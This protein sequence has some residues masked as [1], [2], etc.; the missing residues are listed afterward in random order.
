[1][2]SMFGHLLVR[3][4]ELSSCVRTPG[5]HQGAKARTSERRGCRHNQTLVDV[6]T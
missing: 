1:M 2:A 4:L 3:S 5:T 6:D